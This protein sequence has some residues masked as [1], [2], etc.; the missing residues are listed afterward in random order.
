MGDIIVRGV[1]DALFKALKARAEQDASSVEDVVVRL[2]EEGLGSPG[3]KGEYRDLDALAG[4][5]SEADV[6]EFEQATENL[7]QI[8]R[9][10]WQATA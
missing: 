4:T 1:D 7:R 10:L 9:N 8:D 3:P 6:A 2:I 5:W